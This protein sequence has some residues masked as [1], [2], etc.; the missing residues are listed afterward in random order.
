MVCIVHEG[1][2]PRISTW[3]Q[4][5]REKITNSRQRFLFLI[6]EWWARTRRTHKNAAKGH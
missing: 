1:Y 3:F 4:Y 2:K 5:L 6:Y